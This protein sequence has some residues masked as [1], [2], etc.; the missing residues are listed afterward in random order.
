VVPVPCQARAVAGNQLR[1]PLVGPEREDETGEHDLKRLRELV[2]Q[3]AILDVLES[4]RER[5]V[6]QGGIGHVR[7]VIELPRVG[8]AVGVG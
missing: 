2:E 4:L 5:L 6:P 8:V 3:P 7:G 1:T